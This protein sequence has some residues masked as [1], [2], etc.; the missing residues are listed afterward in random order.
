MIIDQM[1][2]SGKEAYLVDFRDTENF[3][4]ARPSISSVPADKPWTGRSPVLKEGKVLEVSGI[5]LTIVAGSGQNLL[6]QLPRQREPRISVAVAKEMF[7]GLYKDPYRHRV[8]NVSGYEDF[9]RGN[10]TALRVMEVEGV[11]TLVSTGSASCRW[12]SGIYKMP[13]EN[14]DG[15]KGITIGAAAWNLATS[16]KTPADGFDYDLIL[17]YWQNG[18]AN[19]QEEFLI[20]TDRNTPHQGKPDHDRFKDNLAG[21][22]TNVTAYQI[23]FGADVNYDAYLREFHTGPQN[24]ESLGRPLLQ[25]VNILE[26]VAPAHDFYSLHE[27]LLKS[28]DY[29]LFEEQNGPPRRLTVSLDITATLSADEEGNYERLSLTVHPDY[30]TILDY[31]SARLDARVYLR[32]PMAD[33]A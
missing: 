9:K 17:R 21:K 11:P 19:V 6:D 33:S 1:S 32:P 12:I 4:L 25:A 7:P 22:L 13:E 10:L 16:K 3:N 29:H 15:T 18:Q 23:E 31:L 26:E 27:L 5:D 14:A 30:A 28:A 8:H 20:G 24:A 2:L